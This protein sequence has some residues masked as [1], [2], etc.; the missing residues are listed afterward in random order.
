MSTNRVTQ[1]GVTLPTEHER[2]Q[3]F[4]WLKQISSFTAWNRIF[5]FYQ[6]WAQA[7]EECARRATEPTGP[8]ADY[9]LILNGLAHC[10]EAV[11]RLKKGD[12]RIFK[13]DANGELAMADRLPTYWEKMLFRMEDG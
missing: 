11:L 13:F 4:Y 3:I 6:A 12:K 5:G 7:T 10:E 9:R 2:K 1:G 8:A